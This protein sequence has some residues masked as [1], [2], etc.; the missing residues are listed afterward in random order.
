[1]RKRNVLKGSVG[2]GGLGTGKGRRSDLV[3]GWLSGGGFI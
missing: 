1:M 2:K 3:H